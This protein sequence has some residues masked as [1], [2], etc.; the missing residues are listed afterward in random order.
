[1]N[2]KNKYS[3]KIDLSKMPSDI[4]PYIS[5]H[6][7]DYSILGDSL[8]HKRDDFYLLYFFFHRNMPEDAKKY[9]K[10]LDNENKYHKRRKEF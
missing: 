5:A 3:L 9:N 8:R 1:M 6:L 2:S 4:I 7:T 10:L